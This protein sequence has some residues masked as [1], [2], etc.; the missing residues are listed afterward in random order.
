ML[1][2]FSACLALL[3]CSGLSALSAETLKGTFQTADGKSQI[4]MDVQLDD[5]RVKGEMTCGGNLYSVEGNLSEVVETDDFM[6]RKV[7]NL[8]GIHVSPWKM[9]GYLGMAIFASRW[10][11]QMHA[12]RKARKPVMNRAFWLMSLTGSVLL[13]SYFIFGKPDS[14][15]VL[16]NLFPSSVALYNL[17]LDIRHHNEMKTSAENGTGGATV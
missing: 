5:G 1:V 8:F 15:G 14:V 16:S 2:R 11:V 17:Y 9:I 4:Q 6:H 12:S 3:A 13:L 7:I 10:F